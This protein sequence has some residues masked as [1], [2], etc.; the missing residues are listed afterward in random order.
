M[1]GA[2]APDE[3]YGVDADDVAGGEAGGDGVERTAVVG[4]VEGGDEDRVVGDVEV[5]V[6]GGEALAFE[7]DRGGHGE[8]DD[9]ERVAGE[10]AGGAEAVEVLGERQVVFV[11]GAGFDAGEDGVLTIDGGDEAGDV[12]DVAV[13]VV[14]GAAAVEPEG[15]VDAEVV[16]EGL[17]ELLAADAGIALLDFR[18]E[19]FFGGEQDACAVH[20]DGAAFEDEAMVADCGLEFGQAVE[21]RHVVRNLV[22]SVVVRVLG[23]GVELP[24]GDGDLARGV[25]DE[26]GAGVAEP[27][28]VGGPMVEV[29]AG[30]VGSGAEEDA[31]G[32]LFGGL[33]VDEDVDVLDAGEVADDLGVDPGDG[34]EFSGPVLGIVGPRNPGGGMGLPLGGHTV[35]LA[36]RYFHVSVHALRRDP[37]PYLSTKVFYPDGLGMGGICK[38]LNLKDEYF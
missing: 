7:D 37:P 38:V 31:A 13:R 18:E 8:F 20:V 32:A 21:L 25:F 1:E 28:A 17:L 11:V 10:V 12:V 27:D 33:V 22:V 35:V 30:E 26:D 9:M 29:E 2:E 16:V 4:V 5:G 14:A 23:P 34:L 3:V 6:A 15:L 19:A 24:V 36:A